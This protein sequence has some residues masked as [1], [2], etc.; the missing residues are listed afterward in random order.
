MVI[1][2][3]SAWR[4]MMWWKVVMVPGYT[5]SSATQRSNVQCPTVQSHIDRQAIQYHHHSTLLLVT[6]M[7][8]SW[9]QWSPKMLRTKSS[10]RE[11]AAFVWSCQVVTMTTL[12]QYHGIGCSITWTA[13]AAPTLLDWIPSNSFK[14]MAAS[15]HFMKSAREILPRMS[16]PVWWIDSEAINQNCG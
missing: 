8:T 16:W 7:I 5:M 4:V 2:E 3:R 10:Y 11:F 9:Q 15:I 14:N 12:I 1:T 13:A 6:N